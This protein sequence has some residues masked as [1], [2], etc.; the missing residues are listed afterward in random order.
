VSDYQQNYHQPYQFDEKNEKDI[1]SIYRQIAVMPDNDFDIEEKTILFVRLL[2][3]SLQKD[4]LMMDSVEL[5]NDVN[6]LNLTFVTYIKACSL[7]GHKDVGFAMVTF[8]DYYCL[9]YNKVYLKLHDKLKSLV[10][11]G[12]KTMMGAEEY[13]KAENRLNPNRNKTLFELFGGP[14]EAKI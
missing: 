8:C 7:D 14:G 12:L 10:V 13:R 4:R 3:A 1:A 5:T 6:L 9:E 2:E 11:R